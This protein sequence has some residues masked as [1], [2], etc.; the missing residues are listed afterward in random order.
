MDISMSKASRYI[1]ST[2]LCCLVLYSSTGLCATNN[3]ANTPTTL[4]EL[5]HSPAPYE[6]A[7]LSGHVYS[8]DLQEGDPVVWLDPHTQ[9]VHA[10]H[11]WAVYKILTE[12]HEDLLSKA[13]QQLGL[14]YGYRGVI[15]LNAKKKQ[16]VLAHRGTDLNNMSA[17]KTDARS[18]A[19]NVIGGQERIIPLLLAEAITIAQQEKCSLAI[20]GHSLGGWLAQI[21]AFIAKAQYPEHHVK[22]ITFDAPGA[23]P[24]LEQINARINPI[25][26][27]QLDI[28]NYLSS[29]NLINAAN[30]HLIGTTYRVVFKKFGRAAHHYTAKSHAMTNFLQ[31]FDPTTGKAKQCVVVE[32]WPLVSK[33]SLTTTKEMVQGWMSGHPL[34]ALFHLFSLFKRCVQQEHLGEYSGFFK[35][36]RRTNHYHP[37]GLTLEG[38]DQF[39][40]PYK[41]HYKTKPFDPSLMHIRHL[42]RGVYQFLDGVHRGSPPHVAALKQAKQLCAIQLDP[43][44]QVLSAPHGY[45]MRLLADQLISVAWAHPQLCHLTTVLG[46]SVL[47]VNTLLPPPAV[48][49]FVGRQQAL[50]AFR[51]CFQG[52]QDYILAPPI[53]GPG[54]IGKTQ[55]ALRVVNQQAQAAQYDHVFWIPAESEEKLLDAYLRIAEGLG[56]YVDK[57]DLQQA[58]QTI[59]AYLKDQHCLYVFDDAPDIAAIQA[60]L[61]LGQGHVLITSRN[62][63]VSAWPI[64]PLLM[65]PLSEAEALALAQEFGYGQSKEEQAALKPL[66]AKVPCYPLTLVQLFSTLETEG[67]DASSWL[68]AMEH[69]AATAQE[70]TLITLLNERPHAR[71]GYAQSMVYVLKTSLERLAKEQQGVKALQLISQL[72]YLDP[73]G[74]PLEWLLTWDKEDTPPLKRKTRA[75]LSLLEK[76]SLIQW[77]RSAQQVYIHAETQLMVRHLHPQPSLTSLIHRLVDYVGDEEGADQNAAQWSSLLPHGRMLFERL[78]TPQCPQEAYV[79]TKYLAKACIV[80]CLFKEG[81]SWAEKR[82]QIAEQ[83][84]SDQDH[85]DIAWSLDN[86][87]YSL[88]FL[89]NAQ[90]ALAYHKQALA[91][92]KRLYKDQDHP[93]IAAYLNGVGWSLGELGSH[94]EALGYFKQALAMSKQ[95]YKDQ[96]HPHIAAYLNNVGWSLGHLGSHQEALAYHKQALAMSKRLYKDQDHPHIAGHLG[97]VALSLCALGSY[98]EAL[99]YHK[100]TLVMEQRLYKDQDHP[101]IVISLNNVGYILEESGSYQEAL[102]YHK[103]ALAMSKRLYPAQDHPWTV[104]VLNKMGRTLGR[105]G[106]YQE[107]LAYTQEAL[108]MQKRLYKDQD[109]PWVAETLHSLGEA[110]AGLGKFTEAVAHYKKALCMAL[111]VYQKEH[112][113]ITQYLNHLIKTLNKIADQALIQQTKD[114]VLPLCNQWLGAKH[115]LTQQ[116]RD[117]GE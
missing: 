95:V 59:R 51:Q 80:A 76:Y 15:Y 18:I 45:D 44:K 86:V 78:A 79:L 57:K 113:R 68:T 8:D 63:S 104:R 56:I 114:E 32:D 17:I 25:P 27:D 81:V 20:T 73:K 7:V 6:C 31:A 74:I 33:K 1:F 98:Q 87:G 97:S 83:R 64:K 101:Y 52:A 110:L 22:A 16:L 41:Y 75:A 65:D 71:V 48:S 5:Q 72:A 93:H 99:K 58:V 28:T 53:T 42:P 29:P 38:V 3:H 67:Y 84:Y 62:S 61:P 54:G 111:R 112:P 102:K 34:Q 115:P 88:W 77:D 92:S 116:L 49:F 47:A 70:Q 2:A 103:Q 10:L 50:R 60:F 14:P 85:P 4:L 82:L 106:A 12:N 100:Q 117:A 91:M 23:K 96:D 39:D 26:L 90:E 69:Y 19:Q 40:L 35:F 46:H 89:G 24:M 21:T 55:L 30:P 37:Q 109:H 43:P 107:G 9:Q 13:F 94:Q 66:L 36:A 11:G 105:S 108:A